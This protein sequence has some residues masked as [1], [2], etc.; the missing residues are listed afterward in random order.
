MTQV[1]CMH[2]KHERCGK[3]L[4]DIAGGVVGEREYCCNLSEKRWVD[5]AEN[6]PK[7]LSAPQ[8]QSLNEESCT[9]LR[10]CFYTTQ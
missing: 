9:R 3:S 1:N 8:Q 7:L 10:R 2:L 5:C 4:L 6:C